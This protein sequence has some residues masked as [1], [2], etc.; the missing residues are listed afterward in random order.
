M[1]ILSL[2]STAFFFPLLMSSFAPISQADLHLVVTLYTMWNGNSAVN[3]GCVLVLCLTS[4]ICSPSRADL[5]VPC[6]S[7]GQLILGSF[8]GGGSTCTE[9]ERSKPHH[10][11]ITRR[12]LPATPLGAEIGLPKYALI[13]NLAT[14]KHQVG[15]DAK[16]NWNLLAPSP[17]LWIPSD[18]WDCFCSVRCWGEEEG[19]R[20]RERERDPGHPV[21][22]LSAVSWLKAAQPCYCCLPA[23][24]L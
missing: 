20:K 19:G 21:V 11:T 5:L 18:S 14:H 4:T 12:R 8:W 7:P 2:S 17:H 22:S 10:E 15:M 24:S 23:T 3:H 1:H 9:G 13:N 16:T 6:Q